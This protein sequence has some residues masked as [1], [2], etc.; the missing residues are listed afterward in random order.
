VTSIHLQAEDIPEVSW[1][2]YIVKTDTITE[3]RSNL[4]NSVTHCIIERCASMGVIVAE[5]LT[6]LTDR[7]T[8]DKGTHV[9]MTCDGIE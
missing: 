7:T 2:G 4:A 8:V 3:E 1:E 9:G 5:V 6:Y